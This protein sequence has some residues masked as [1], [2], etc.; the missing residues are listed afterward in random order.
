MQNRKF[1]KMLKD[2][3]QFEG[4]SVKQAYERLQDTI[5]A[6]QQ[7]PDPIVQARWKSIP[8][9]GKQVTVEKFFEYIDRIGPYGR[10]PF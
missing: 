4:I 2:V 1:Q 8:H 5:N 6:A 9:K 10:L 3:A 7:D